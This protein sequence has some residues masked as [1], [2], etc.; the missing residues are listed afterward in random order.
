MIG[1]MTIIA[2]ELRCPATGSRLVQEGSVL[3]AEGGLQSYSKVGGHWSL[4]PNPLPAKLRDKEDLWRT[5]QKHGALSYEL[6]PDQNLSAG[7]FAAQIREAMGHVLCGS[8]LDIGCG[9]QATTP[10]YLRGLRDVVGIDPLS[11]A[12]IREFPFYIAI[13]EA[14]PF[15]SDSFDHAV[16]CSALDHTLDFRLALQE[17]IRVSRRSVVVWMDDD[18]EAGFGH[19]IGRGMTQFFRAIRRRGLM[20]AIRYSAAIA[21]M[22]IPKGA[23]DMFHSHFPTRDEVNE[24]FHQEGIAHV[25]WT[26]VAGGLLA[27]ASKS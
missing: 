7:A 10:E 13:A 25:E 12:D 4:V 6:D 17:A 1:G 27:S 18:P 16:F 21:A 9:P 24:A 20:F 8:V 22:P 15:A 5:L 11:G 2:P 3:I 14:L 26:S 23:A 19:L